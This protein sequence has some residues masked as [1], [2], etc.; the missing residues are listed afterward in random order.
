[1]GVGK[2]TIIVIC[3]ELT[4]PSLY[5]KNSFVAVLFRLM[6][7]SPAPDFALGAA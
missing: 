3:R 1:M 6:T 7:S 5:A 4:N 2:L